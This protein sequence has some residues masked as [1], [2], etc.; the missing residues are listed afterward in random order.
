[1]RYTLLLSFILW[2]HTAPVR[3]A[4]PV[5]VASAGARVDALFADVD[6]THTPG[7]AVGVR[8]DG[9]WLLRKGYGMANLDHA[10]PIGPD[11]RFRIASISKQFTAAAVLL[12]VEQGR[13]TLDQDI[14]SILTDLPDY[15]D[16]VRVRHLLTH[17]SGLPDYG[18]EVG[19]GPESWPDYYNAFPEF[20]REDDSR[21]QDQFFSISRFYAGIRSVGTLKFRPGTHFRYNN[22][23]YFLLSQIVERVTG[24]TLR[25]FADENIFQPLG[26]HD[27]FFNDRAREVVPRRADGY[28]TL[29][30]GRIIRFNTALN[31]VGDGGVFTTLD[32]FARWDDNF[33]HNRLGP[34]WDHIIAQMT[35]P[36]TQLI[37]DDPEDRD[38]RG[39]YGFGLNITERN[40][41]LKVHHGGHFV[42]FKGDQVR[43]PALKFSTFIFCNTPQIEPWERSD[44]I[45]D[46]YLPAIE[47]QSTRP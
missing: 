5:D 37:Y 4:A 15:G 14:R 41:R 2:A 16:V 1:M 47:Q 3:A 38:Y 7:C 30:D 32:D 20:F 42:G 24:K 43:Y 10:I 34:A 39:N 26:M 9:H 46:I 12:L 29:P 44:A 40:G 23:G 21:E 22:A 31:M 45:A 13:L 36:N 28:L 25:E 33:Y 18:P 17:S 35:T 27:T 8:H 6:T 19:T 11:T